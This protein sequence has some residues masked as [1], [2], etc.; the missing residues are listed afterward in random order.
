MT[1]E[2]AELYEESRWDNVVMNVS[3]GAPYAQSRV[4]TTE[5]HTLGMSMSRM[6]C[7][8]LHDRMPLR[9]KAWLSENC[10]SFLDRI[11]QLRMENCTLHDSDIAPRVAPTAMADDVGQRGAQPF[12]PRCALASIGGADVVQFRYVSYCR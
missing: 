8:R 2:D 12:H 5:G 1:V 11:Q 3:S 9:Q 10:W 6:Q 4:D 7:L